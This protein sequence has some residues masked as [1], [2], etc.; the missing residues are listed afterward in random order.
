MMLGYDFDTY[1]YGKEA[2]PLIRLSNW[3]DFGHFPDVIKV[4]V[5]DMLSQLVLDK[6]SDFFSDWNNSS[7][8]SI[9]D[10]QMSVSMFSDIVL[11]IQDGGEFALLIVEVIIIKL[12]NFVPYCL[13]F[14]MGFNLPDSIK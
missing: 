14:T 11:V 6:L 4:S 5:L 13:V 1:K 3:V 7:F 10:T 8:H 9:H 12:D 2:V